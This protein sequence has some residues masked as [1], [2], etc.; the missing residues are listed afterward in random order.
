MP[1]WPAALPQTVDWNNFKE[2]TKSNTLR[3]QPD[4]GPFKSRPRVSK[5]PKGF[6]VQLSLLTSDQVDALMSFY[7]EDCAQGS[8]AFDWTHPRT[9]APIS[10]TFAGEISIDAQARNKFMASFDFLILT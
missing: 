8:I 3:S 4:V 9:G 2:M 5:A 10:A 1:S 6:S 7:D